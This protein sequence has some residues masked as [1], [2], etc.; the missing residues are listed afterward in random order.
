V[1][2][3]RGLDLAAQRNLSSPYPPSRTVERGKDPESQNKAERR[4]K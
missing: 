1:Q 4:K 3:F 2:S